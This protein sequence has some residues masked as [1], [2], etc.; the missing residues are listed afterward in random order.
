MSAKA[1]IGS[2]LV[3]MAANA[4]GCA[5]EPMADDPQVSTIDHEVTTWCSGVIF[6]EEFT[7]RPR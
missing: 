1:T 3:V 6:R 4:A 7:L 2:I 5:V